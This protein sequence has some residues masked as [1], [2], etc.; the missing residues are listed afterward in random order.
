MLIV[1][2]ESAPEPLRARRHRW[3]AERDLSRGDAG[4]GERAGAE[5]LGREADLVRRVP[6]RGRRGR[7]RDVDRQADAA[8][9]RRRA[10]A[11]GGVLEAEVAARPADLDRDRHAARLEV[12]VARV[13]LEPDGVDAGGTAFVWMLLVR[14][15]VPFLAGMKTSVDQVGWF[16]S[17]AAGGVTGGSGMR[18]YSGWPAAAASRSPWRWSVTVELNESL[19]ETTKFGPLASVPVGAQREARRRADGEV[20]DL[21]DR[22][23]VDGEQ[24]PVADRVGVGE[25]ADHHRG[26]VARHDRDLVVGIGRAGDRRE[27]RARIAGQDVGALHVLQGLHVR[28]R[29]SRRCSRRATIVS[30]KLR[31]S[32][33]MNPRKSDALLA[34]AP[35]P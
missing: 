16:M 1:I 33:A 26:V 19:R 21:H 23:V 7:R 32:R 24:D 25:V 6:L 20:R 35:G 5:L 34:F 31:T 11:Q 18:S 12:R 8:A 4:G 29:R 9:Q 27:H 2:V 14:T 10:A 17:P 13:S 3:R 15:V 22:A 30:W 28:A